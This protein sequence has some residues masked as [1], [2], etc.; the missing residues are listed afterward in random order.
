MPHKEP[1]FDAERQ[2]AEPA[3]AFEAGTENQAEISLERRQQIEGEDYASIEVIREDIAANRTAPISSSRFRDDLYGT[4]ASERG[5]GG[6]IQLQGEAAAAAEKMGVDFHRSAK[7]FSNVVAGEKI[8]AEYDT[9]TNNFRA[10]TRIAAL[11]DGRKAFMVYDYGGSWLHRTM[12]GAMKRMNGLPMRKAGRGEWKKLHE[13][14]TSIPVIENSDPHMAMM[15]YV[16][17]ANGKDVFANN[18]EIKDFGSCQWAKEAGLEE[19]NILSRKIVD[20]M[21]RFHDEKG[22]WGE[23][24]L[25]N[26]IFTERQEPVMCDFE[27]VYNK[28]ISPAEAKA[29]D[30]KDMCISIGAALEGAHGQ[31]VGETVRI[32]LDRYNDPEVIAEIKKL[33]SRK[34][35]FFKNLVFGYEQARTGAKSKKQYDAVHA[36]IIAYESPEAA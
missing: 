29:R 34:R 3:R 22:A 33:A 21:K 32:V 31:D 24:V 5:A 2:E 20:E 27:V 11:P 17:N 7:A 26:V 8:A 30:L 9:R 23:A 18:G 36:A 35:G 1:V 6:K 19:K 15:P 14:K 12:D 4:F 25:S 16:P 28:K 13:A 10:Q